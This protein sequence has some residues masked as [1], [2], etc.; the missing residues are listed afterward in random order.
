MRVLIEAHLKA[1]NPNAAITAI[2]E[3]A[4]A[5]SAPSTVL[6]ASASL[7]L[8]RLHPD[9]AGQVLDRAM[10]LDPSSMTLRVSR[11]EAL[12]DADV[13]TAD[14]PGGPIATAAAQVTARYP[15]LA[16]TAARIA[17]GLSSRAFLHTATTIREASA[18]PLT[19]DHLSAL[20]DE[21]C[22]EDGDC[23][24]WSPEITRRWE[25]DAAR[26]VRESPDGAFASVQL[27][28]LALGRAQFPAAMLERLA[29]DAKAQRPD[30]P[31][32][33]AVLSGAVA[34]LARGDDAAA[35]AS[36]DTVLELGG[37]ELPAVLDPR[38]R[39]SGPHSAQ[40]LAAGLFMAR[41][42]GSG[43]FDAAHRALD[44]AVRNAGTIDG[45]LAAADA[46]RDALERYPGTPAAES[47]RLAA[48]AL[49]LVDPLR[50]RGAQYVA[51]TSLVSD[52]W[53]KQS[54]LVTAEF[55]YRQA[56]E[57]FP[58]SPALHNNLAYFL[59]RHGDKLEDALAL[60]RR[61]HALAPERTLAYV[62]TEA[63]ILH[64][65]GRHGEAKELL[66]EALRLATR[67]DGS[68]LGESYY[69]LGVVEDALGNDTESVRALKLSIRYDRGGY[70]G[71]SATALLK[72][73][74]K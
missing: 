23:G 33:I 69:H 10:A 3:W 9:A 37:I 71:R 38:R 53:E 59:S 31:H 22:V 64:R 13:T 61:A 60:I 39:A 68:G 24:T 18:L 5:S 67:Q 26:F 48:A 40:T 20:V 8:E 17:D 46:V 56:L 57:R 36:L 73:K 45:R 1:G 14:T 52:L 62:D 21:A 50:V 6:V 29:A 43:R 2:D 25:A 16:A 51:L 41:A 58:A 15:D 11:L 19:L 55:V 35:L 70:F 44:R 74:G 47:R 32:P 49:A 28:A 72:K 34:S 66:R 63:W 12:L 65:L 4:A 30:A 54:D 42:V 27:C 7:L